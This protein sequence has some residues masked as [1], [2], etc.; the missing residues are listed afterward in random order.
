MTKVY[1]KINGTEYDSGVST[2]TPVTKPVPIVEPS[3]DHP[4]GYYHKEEDKIICAT[5]EGNF[6]KREIQSLIRDPYQMLKP[7][8]LA[9]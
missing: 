4:S 9:L 5:F 3:R 6:S 2:P 7:T 8:A 1:I